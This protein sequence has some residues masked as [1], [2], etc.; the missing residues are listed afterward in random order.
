MWEQ[1]VELGSALLQRT[2]IS[3]AF[4][5]EVTA[6]TGSVDGRI[7]LWKKQRL[8]SAEKGH[9]GA[10]FDLD[11]SRG[12]G[13]FRGTLLITMEGARK[14]VISL[15]SQ[16]ARSEEERQVLADTAM[17][18]WYDDVTYDI[19]RPPSVKSAVV[20]W[21]AAENGGMA[22][23]GGREVKVWGWELE[24]CVGFHGFGLGDSF[25]RFSTVGRGRHKWRP[26]SMTIDEFFA[27]LRSVQL[28]FDPNLPHD[29]AARLRAV[30]EREGRTHPMVTSVE[31]ARVFASAEME[32]IGM[33]EFVQMVG[34]V[35]GLVVAKERGDTPHCHRREKLEMDMVDLQG[36]L[37]DLE[38]RA[39]SLCR[40]F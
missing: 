16:G 12:R 20:S 5:D 18:R 17:Q 19:G 10:V 3:A 34:Q 22:S 33:E 24:L 13:L 40:Q 38:R 26:R 30:D 2:C 28:L 8:Q 11:S 7:Y 32:E 21:S 37:S 14:D 23:C 4:L 27:F 29:T 25:E 39:V 35:V 9:D 31:A 6:V 1:A 15:L 36:H